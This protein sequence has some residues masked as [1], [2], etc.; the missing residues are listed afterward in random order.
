VNA[1]HPEDRT[2]PPG[3]EALELF[4]ATWAI[5]TLAGRVAMRGEASVQQRA[6]F[7]AAAADRLEPALAYLDGKPRD[8]PD[9]C[10]ARLMQLM[11]SLAHVALAEEVQREDE[12]THTELR[13]FMPITRTFPV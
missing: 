7:Y 8:L 5:P 3:F 13:S 12:P 1:V 4:V 2:L 6:S 11:L 10:D 9:A